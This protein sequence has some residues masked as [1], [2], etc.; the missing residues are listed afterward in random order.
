MSVETSSPSPRGRRLPPVQ[1][2]SRGVALIRVGVIS[3]LAAV[4]IL[5]ALTIQMA[6]GNDPALGPKLE[7]RSSSSTPAA[8]QA[9]ATSPSTPT[10]PSPVPPVQIAQQSVPAPS[11]VQTSVS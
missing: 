11:P 9:Q 5:G 8:A 6:A 2:I 1:R 3:F 7:R 10:A 4:V